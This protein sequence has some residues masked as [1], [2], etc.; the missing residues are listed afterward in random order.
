MGIWKICHKPRVGFERQ[1]T[2]GQQWAPLFLP[3]LVSILIVEETCCRDPRIKFLSQPWLC[4]PSAADV[5]TPASSTAWT[6][7][8]GLW[9]GRVWSSHSDF[10]SGSLVLDLYESKGYPLP[11]ILSG[12]RAHL[13]DWEPS[14]CCEAAV[15]RHTWFLECVP[16]TR[17]VGTHGSSRDREGEVPV[18]GGQGWPWLL[19]GRRAGPESQK[20]ELSA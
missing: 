11:Q 5:R 16:G 2:R 1:V 4:F 17:V 6:W 3:G 8:P 19:R 10:V 15:C 18:G 12:H 7:A 14:S 9:L 20:R 13:R